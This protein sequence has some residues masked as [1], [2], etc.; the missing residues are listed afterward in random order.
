[1]TLFINL[2]LLEKTDKL[3]DII[4]CQAF[5]EL[6]LQNTLHFLL[7]TAH[8]YIIVQLPLYNSNF[9]KSP[10]IA[11]FLKWFASLKRKISL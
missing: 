2:V 11:D 6:S 8:S 3:K 9:L 4:I 7:S 5:E 10:F 1:M